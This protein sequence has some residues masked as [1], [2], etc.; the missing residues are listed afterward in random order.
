MMFYINKYLAVITLLPDAPT[1][2]WLIYF[3]RKIRVRRRIVREKI[4]EINSQVEDA[5]QGIRETKS[6]TGEE[7]EVSRF[8]QANNDYR[9]AEESTYKIYNIFN[10]GYIRALGDVTVPSLLSSARPIMF[11]SDS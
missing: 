1:V 9:M 7:R 8:N 10:S 6:F 5:I 4:A 3:E 11:F 2:G